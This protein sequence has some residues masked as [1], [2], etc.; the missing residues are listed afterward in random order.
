[1]T[2]LSETQA[3]E[4]Q[5][6]DALRTVQDPDL[7]KDLVTLNMIRDLQVLPG[8]IVQF[9]VVLTTPAC[10]LKAKIEA[11][12]REAVGAVRGISRIEI[13]MDAEVRSH[14][15]TSSNSVAGVKNIIAVSSGKGGVGKSTI[16]S[17]LAVGLSLAGAR[18]GLMDADIYGPN[19]PTMMGVLGEP[20]IVTDEK[21]KERFIP[22]E[23]HGI[24]VMSMG[25]L[26]ERDQPMIWRG[27][28]LHNVVN[29]F[30]HMV[31]W[32]NLDYLIVDMPPGTGDVQ[33]SLAQ[34][35]PMTGAVM[36]STPQEVAMQDVRKG[37]N[38][39]EKVRVPILGIVENMSYFRCDQCDKEHTI[40]G[41]GGGELLSKKF[42]TPLLG[43]VPIMTQVRE[44]GDDGT[45]ILLSH[46]KSEA[47]EI[48]REIA[49]KVAQQVSLLGQDR[50]ATFEPIQIGKF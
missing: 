37:L 12:C 32:G 44:S 1:M 27:P 18:V 31:D 22:P 16:A 26:I 34:L 45:P 43:R 7:H 9:R 48:L 29:Q 11:D 39:W 38:M 10:P 3:L 15:S 4:K 24:K 23:S 40:F 13:K 28:M 21:G 17:N 47:A 36:V 20:K 46:P 30:C 6:L 35:V 5:V 41:S 49:L 33:L 14:Q 50:F 42:K 25:F 8:G 2:T 19:M